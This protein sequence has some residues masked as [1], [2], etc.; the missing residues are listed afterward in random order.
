MAEATAEQKHESNTH[1]ASWSIG[2]KAARLGDLNASRPWLLEAEPP[3]SPLL[4]CD[5]SKFGASRNSAGSRSFW[6]QKNALLVPKFRR[7][8]I[9][10]ASSPRANQSMEPSS[11]RGFAREASQ[12]TLCEA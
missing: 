10:A 1:G 3:G 9:R 6:S 11:L 2:R 5:F 7:A 4:S 12:G 8:G